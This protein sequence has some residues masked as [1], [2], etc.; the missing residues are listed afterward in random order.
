MINQ[1]G[2]ESNNINKQRVRDFFNLTQ[3]LMIKA[4]PQ[5]H[6]MKHVNILKNRRPKPFLLGSNP[7]SAARKSPEFGL[8][9]F[10]S[11]VQ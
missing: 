11:I 1:F 2:Q 10:Y 9:L 6:V 8:F 5:K 3:K 7:S 4:S